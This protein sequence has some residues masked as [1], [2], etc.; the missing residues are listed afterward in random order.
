[1]LRFIKQVLEKSKIH[2]NFWK[3]ATLTL[4]VIILASIVAFLEIK[5]RELK[6]GKISASQNS[7]SSN[8]VV[9]SN[10]EEETLRALKEIENNVK[11]MKKSADWKESEETS[12]RLKEIFQGINDSFDTLERN[13]EERKRRREY[14]ERRQK[15]A[16]ELQKE[17]DERIANVY[18]REQANKSQNTNTSVN[19]IANSY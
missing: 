14:D 9:N 7:S 4:V 8:T 11:A 18:K 15:L 3:Y 13:R 5:N 1:M 10:N 12:N 2:F 6:Q 17:Q 16:D 19:S